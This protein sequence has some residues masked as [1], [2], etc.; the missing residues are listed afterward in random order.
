MAGGG[1]TMLPLRQARDV[2]H[3][4]HHQPP[5]GRVSPLS[6]TPDGAARRG[7]RGNYLVLMTTN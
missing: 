4:R 5:L 6:G 1:H 2:G 7:E 3:A